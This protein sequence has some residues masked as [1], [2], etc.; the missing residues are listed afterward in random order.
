MDKRNSG[1]KGRHRIE[2]QIDSG[3]IKNGDLELE[4]ISD[5]KKSTHMYIN[6]VFF[7]A[8]SINA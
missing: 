6:E 3:Q 8:H 2:Q 7:P 1:C 5:I 4:D